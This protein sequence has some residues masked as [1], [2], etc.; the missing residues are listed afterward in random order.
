MKKIFLTIIFIFMITAI[1]V[2]AKG[3]YLHTITLEKNNGSYN[4][5]LDTD[6]ISKVTRKVLSE[7]EIVLDVSDISAAD[8]VNALYKGTNEVDNLVIENNE[9]NN[10]KIYI[11][12]AN[13]KDA[14]V[15]IKP[16]N[17]EGIITGESFPV[18]KAVWAGFVILL[19]AGIFAGAKKVSEQDAKILIKQDI[20]DREIQMYRKYRKNLEQ[21]MSISSNDMKMKSM[22]KKIDR[23]IDERLSASYR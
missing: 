1:A 18:K 4:V 17:G 5:I 21:N 23:K 3:N 2:Q 11:T 13:I 20:K 7:R 19:F 8:T 16:V 14:S 10:L 12:A 9:P 15:I 6:K 22:L